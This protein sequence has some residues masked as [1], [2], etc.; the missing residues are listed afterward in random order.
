[1]LPG[2]R[3]LIVLDNARDADQVRP[4]LPGS[5]GCLVLVTSRDQL[6][7]LLADHDAHLLTLDLFTAS[8]ARALLARRLGAGRV[9]AEPDAVDQIA[10]RCTRLPLALTVITARAAAHP[11]FPLATLADELT[12]TGSRLDPFTGG[13]RATDARTVFSWS[14]R[15]LST[16]S[17]RLFRLLGLHPGPDTGVAA[18]ASLA[19][20]TARQ[21]RPLLA[22][23]TRAHLLTEH[24][25]GR[26]TFHDLLREYATEQAHSLDTS[27]ERQAALDRVLDYYLHTAH[28]HAMLLHPYRD[29][30][31]LPSPQ[32]GV[33]PESLT[34]SAQA[35]SWF[36]TER[37]VLLA[38]ANLA[39]DTG[40]DAHAWQLA[41]TM[42]TFLD[43]RGHRHDM[44]AISRCGLAAAN[45]LAD[46]AAQAPTHR[47]LAAA[48]I[49]LTR[50][51]E[52]HTHLTCALDLY[53][54]IG[55]LT[56]QAHAHNNFCTFYERQRRHADALD[57]ARQALDLYRAAGHR[58]G[59]AHGLN[60][61]GWFQTLLGDHEQA[62]TAC[63]QALTMLQ[64][65]GDRAGQA[66]T[67]DSLG[68]AHHHLGHHRQA[69]TCL[70]HALHL[71]HD[72]GDRYHEAH[73]LTRIG[74]THHAVGDHHAA[75]DAWKQALTIF[76][77]FDHSD[78]E[79]IHA[80]LTA[81]PV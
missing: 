25:P 62:L 32:P 22:E 5:G 55:D 42:W 35:L 58:R 24:T 49:N 53:R 73:I 65:L 71:L 78:T 54:D 16:D 57:H 36:T 48:C 13:D 64:D 45:R 6:T 77:D 68:H 80:R 31:P 41:W 56:G 18:A 51:D 10:A 81:S 14:Y 38:A 12:Q 33:T 37:P 63:Q 1:M 76:Q 4:L 79:H 44:L 75:H 34:D 70:Q 74:D 9:A 47:L 19:A 2:R 66:Y 8:E 15:T 11:D 59:Q 46:P 21:V 7:G 29:P 43:R 72:I 52:A 17:A 40:L 39:A 3:M 26:Y 28:A 50:Y 67:W 30:I 27:D 20:L 61:V 60:T 23:L 69:L